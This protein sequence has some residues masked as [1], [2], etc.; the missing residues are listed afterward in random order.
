MI[1]ANSVGLGV[2]IGVGD[3]Y[4]RGFYGEVNIPK[5]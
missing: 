3:G 2:D 4:C 5:V 1:T